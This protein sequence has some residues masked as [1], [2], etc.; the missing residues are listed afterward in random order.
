MSAR[1]DIVQAISICVVILAHNY[2]K[3]L[4]LSG[5]L[6][7]SKTALQEAVELEHTELVTILIKA[8]AA[9]SAKVPLLC[10][11]FVYVCMPCVV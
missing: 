9:A 10:W 1:L 11:C 8:T 4:A 2:D 6:Q 5:C 3:P 7:T